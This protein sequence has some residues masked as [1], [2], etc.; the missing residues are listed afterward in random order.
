MTPERY[1]LTTPTAAP[2][3]K[4]QVTITKIQTIIN[5]QIQNLK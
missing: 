2:Q 1:H 4:R 3:R 5:N